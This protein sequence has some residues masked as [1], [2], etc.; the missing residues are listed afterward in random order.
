MDCIAEIKGMVKISKECISVRDLLDL[1]NELTYR[2]PSFV[3]GEIDIFIDFMENEECIFIPILFFERNKNTFFKDF[4]IADKRYDKI[5]ENEI[6]NNIEL[7]GPE[8][9][10]NQKKIVGELFK[11]MKSGKTVGIIKS[12]VGTGKSIMMLYVAYRSKRKTLILV[13]RSSLLRQFVKLIKDDKV[14]DNVKLGIIKG[15]KKDVEGKDIVIGMIETALMPKNS[16]LLQDFGLLMIDEV[17]RVAAPVYIKSIKFCPAKNKLGW[18]ATPERKDGGKNLLKNNMGDVIVNAFKMGIGGSPVKP[19]IIMIGHDFKIYTKGR[20]PKK[21]S[22]YFENTINGNEDRNSI[23]MSLVMHLANNKDRNILV[24]TNRTHMITEYVDFLRSEGYK[25]VISLKGG[26][27]DEAIEK[28]KHTQIIISNKQ[29]I[30]V[31]VSLNHLNTLVFA[32][33][34]AGGLQQKVGRITRKDDGKERLVFDIVD[35]TSK[36]SREI[37]KM[38]IK[39]YKDKL[40]VNAIDVHYYRWGNIFKR[41]NTTNYKRGDFLEEENKI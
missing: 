34:I 40:K 15:N 7:R 3:E 28:A 20:E 38:K 14:L 25:S 13:H 1:K 8:N 33:F 23:I 21:A 26:V 36:L 31:G 10:I 24:M 16:H 22:S 19:H 11:K 29:F 39:H 27:K 17:E 9:K 2:S 37:S 12:D 35:L 41:I 30:S 6:I 18:S 5:V 4:K 32:G